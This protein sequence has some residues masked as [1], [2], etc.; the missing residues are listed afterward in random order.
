MKNIYWVIGIVIILVIGFLFCIFFSYR[1]CF[2][3]HTSG[4]STI[5]YYKVK[6]CDI[7][8]ENPNGCDKVSTNSII[9][10]DADADK[11]NELDPGTNWNWNNP[12]SNDS[13]DN[14]AALC[15]GFYNMK[16]ETYCKMLC[17]CSL[18]SQDDPSLCDRSCESDNDCK[19]TCGCECISK[20]EECKFTNILCEAPDPS[21]A[22]KCINKDCRFEKII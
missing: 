8:L 11:D 2:S 20:N 3:Y 12:E 22:C 9:I 10:N 13:Q 17:G 1:S 21:Y 7:L 4:P 14:L 5:E 15:Y 18:C 16:N 19:W 6:Y